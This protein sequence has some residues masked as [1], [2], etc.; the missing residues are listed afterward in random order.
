MFAPFFFTGPTAS[1]KSAVAVLLAERLGGEIVNADAFQLY[2]GMDVLT[3]K[4]EAADLERVPHHLYS[5]LPAG[6]SCDAQRYREMALPV[7][8]DIAERGRLP[9][10]VGGSGLYVKA[11]SHGL[12]ELPP[13]DPALRAELA[14][15]SLEAKQARLLEL[16]PDAA[17]NVPLANP[18][19]VERAL[20][21]CL[22]TGRPQSQ[23]RR[24]FAE[25]RPLGSGVTLDLPRAELHERIRLRLQGMLAAG[26]LDE[27]RVLPETGPTAARAIGLR[28]LRAHLAGELSLDEALASMEAATRRYAKRQLTWFRRETWLQ[29]ICLP[30]G[31]TAEWA[32]DLILPH[33]PCP[34]NPPPSTSV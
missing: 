16:D 18:R 5:V 1:G 33:V 28:E 13:A 22:L 14:G 8:A 20:E 19:Y 11:L 2:E 12:A 9:I 6:E 30:A 17:T 3:A 34:P 31:A 24:S 10:V 7:L 25:A 4:P 29:S 15:W 32:L 23:L 21:I 27:V 26:L